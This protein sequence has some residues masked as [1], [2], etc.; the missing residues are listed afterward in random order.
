MLSLVILDKMV[1]SSADYLEKNK[2]NL[3]TLPPALLS[4]FPEV[5]IPS[6]KSLVIAG[7]TV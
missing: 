3:A 4:V 7:D 5:S 2:I 1:V 6:L